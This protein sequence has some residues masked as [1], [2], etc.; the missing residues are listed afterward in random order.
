[1]K[2]TKFMLFFACFVL[3]MA[4]LVACDDAL[5]DLPDGLLPDGVLPDDGIVDDG[6]TPDEGDGPDVDN[7]TDEGDEPNE[8]ETP[9]DVLPDE[10]IVTHTVIFMDGNGGVLQ[11]L[12]VPHGAAIDLSLI[13]PPTGNAP[14]VTWKKLQ[15]DS[16]ST[17]TSIVG[18]VTFLPVFDDGSQRYN[19]LFTFITPDGEVLDQPIVRT[20]VAYGEEVSLPQGYLNRVTKYDDYVAYGWDSDGDGQPDNGYKNITS[21]MTI[22]ALFREKQTFTA[23]FYSDPRTTCQVEV[24]EGCAVDMSQVVY[25]PIVGQIFRG[26]EKAD[27]AQESS[28]SCMLDD[29]SFVARVGKINSVIPMVE[30]NTITVDG[31]KDIAYLSGT[32]LPINEERHAD[33]AEGSFNSAN[34]QAARPATRNDVIPGT[35]ERSSWITA[36]AWLLWDGDYVYVLIEVSDKTLTYRNPRYVQTMANAWLNDCIELYFDFEQDLSTTVN[37]KKVGM[38]ALGQRLFSNSPTSIAMRPTHYGEITGAARSALGYYDGSVKRA[39]DTS[40][41]LVGDKNLLLTTDNVGVQYA[42]TLNDTKHY[43]YRVE[44]AIPAK[45]EGVPDVANYHVD[46]NGRLLSAPQLTSGD[47]ML[48]DMVDPDYYRF[49]DGEKLKVGSFVRFSASVHD[50]M[51]TPDRLQ[52]RNS[53]FYDDPATGATFLYSASN[54]Q[55]YPPFVPCGNTQTQLSGYVT[56]ALGSSNDAARWEVYELKGNGVNG[57]MKDENGNTIV[58]GSRDYLVQ[59]PRS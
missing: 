3:L 13:T 54:S 30:K 49:T 37:R 11:T 28:L 48:A 15:S 12:T 47:S 55:V 57:V 29:A 56:F 18:N 7:G 52:D 26:W 1:M 5:P 22:N 8:D 32:Y 10:E 42:Q 45:T 20:G 44:F 38:D 40:D 27:P 43:S 17:L 58:Q 46:A 6:L 4:L 36:D 24:K 51:V 34:A 35:G 33:R 23:T 25:Y 53:G 31:K 41:C 21:N 16:L 2:K 39:Y 9:D 19:V 59:I 50:L 14:F